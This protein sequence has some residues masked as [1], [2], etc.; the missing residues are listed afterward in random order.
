[1][2]EWIKREKLLWVGVI[3][4]LFHKQRLLP[5]TQA[6][7]SKTVIQRLPGF[8]LYSWICVQTVAGKS[9][10]KSVER[11]FEGQAN[12]SEKKS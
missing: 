6:Y 4:D 5:A 9:K 7:A 10:S 11:R 2:Q 3:V 8:V 12:N 1:M